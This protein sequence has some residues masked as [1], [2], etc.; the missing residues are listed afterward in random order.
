MQ[1]SKYIYMCE[2][3]I[4]VQCSNVLAEGQDWCQA[5]SGASKIPVLERMGICIYGTYLPV[6]GS[7]LLATRVDGARV[8]AVRVDTARVHK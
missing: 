2:T 3:D 7:A 6:V 8:D 1:Y 5:T 4:Y